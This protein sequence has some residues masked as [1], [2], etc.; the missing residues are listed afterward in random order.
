MNQPNNKRHQDTVKRIQD[1]MLALLDEKDFERITVQDV[2]THAEINRSTFYRHYLD[3]YDLMEKLE[4]K[5]QSGIVQ[6]WTAEKDSNELITQAALQRLLTYILEHRTFYRAYLREYPSRNH[7]EEMQKIFDGYLQPLFETYGVVGRNHMQYYY[8]FAS[9]GFLT[10]IAQ[11]LEQDTP[12]S[13]EEIAGILYAMLRV[14][15]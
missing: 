2:C 10:V 8:H 3:I 7:R 14:P 5:I 9:A 15:K 13:P 4:R 6:Q 12:E 1:A 11:W